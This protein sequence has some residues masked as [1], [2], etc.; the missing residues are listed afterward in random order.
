MAITLT[1]ARAVTYKLVDDDGTW[2]TESDVDRA[3]EVALD[4]TVRQYAARGGVLLDQTIQ[5]NTTASGLLDLS[6]YRPVVIKS[7]AV[8]AGNLWVPVEGGDGAGE[9]VELSGVKT[10]RVTLVGSAEFPSVGGDTIVYGAGA[11]ST[12]P[13]MD[14]LICVKAAQHLKPTTGDVNAALDRQ[15]QRLWESVFSGGQ[16]PRVF[17]WPI[18]KYLLVDYLYTYSPSS[19]VQLLYRQHISASG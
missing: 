11:S 5:L 6:S 7:V 16:V 9:A 1:E 3:L 19:G 14:Q 8:Q 2:W 15:E 4:E 18:T 10:L 17:D 13:T 12:F